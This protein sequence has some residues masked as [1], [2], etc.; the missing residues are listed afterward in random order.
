L[1]AA[2]GRFGRQGPRWYD[3][4]LTEAADPAV[5]EGG[6]QTTR[7]TSCH[8]WTK[9]GSREYLRLVEGYRVTHSQLVPTMF[10]WMLKRPE[11]VRG[12][13]DLSSLEVAVHAGAPWPVPVKEQMIDW[14]GP[15]LGLYVHAFRPGRRYT[16]R[17]D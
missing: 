5:T 8:R 14:W 4:A 9:V 10:S 1:A 17:P 15:V 6:E 3:W 13:P 7:W 12:R 11:E 16:P 2:V